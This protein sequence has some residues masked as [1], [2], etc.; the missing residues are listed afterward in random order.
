MSTRGAYGYRYKGKEYLLYNHFDSYF[1]GLGANL[2]NAIKEL[3]IDTM[4]KAVE[5]IVVVK[6]NDE[7]TDEQYKEVIDA[8]VKE[9][10]D[11]EIGFYGEK[12]SAKKWYYLLRSIQFDAKPFLDGSIKYW[13]VYNEFIDDETFCEWAYILDL[14]SEIL[15]IYSHGRNLIMKMTFYFIKTVDI[16]VEMFEDYLYMMYYQDQDDIDEFAKNYTN[17]TKISKK[18]FLEIKDK[19]RDPY[20]A[21]KYINDA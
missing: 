5:N 18:K 1:S 8:G 16:D 4:R 3:D 7:A 19:I 6:T 20:S 14:D 17:K 21:I 13:P 10:E 2:I 12:E 9:I 11:S 15:E